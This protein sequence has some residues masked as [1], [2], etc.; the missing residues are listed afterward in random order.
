MGEYS[1]RMGYS[2]KVNGKIISTMIKEQFLGIKKK[3][4]RI[5]S[6]CTRDSL[7]KAKNKV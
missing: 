5:C 6:L 7:K 3:M 4:D 1:K 2:T